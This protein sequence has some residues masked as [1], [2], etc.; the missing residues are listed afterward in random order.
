VKIVFINGMPRSGKDT[1]VELAQE[2]GDRAGVR[3]NAISSIDPVRSALKSF[4]LDPEN[5]TPAMRALMSEIGDSMERWLGYRSNYCLENAI[6]FD[7]HG[8]HIMFIHMR[9]PVL[10]EKTAAMLQDEGYSVTRVY[11]RSQRAETVETNA[12][13]TGTW[14]EDFYQYVITNDGTIDDLRRDAILLLKDLKPALTK[15]LALT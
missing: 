5:K 13:D 2:E 12:S 14:R 8:R 10:I 15:G 7:R 4:N 6:E 9:E 3:V 11:I 1:F